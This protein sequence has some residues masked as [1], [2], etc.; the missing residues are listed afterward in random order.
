[1]KCRIE[2]DSL[3]NCEGGWESHRWEVGNQDRKVGEIILF[4]NQC[5]CEI[6]TFVDVEGYLWEVGEVNEDENT[7]YLYDREN[8]ECDLTLQVV[9]STA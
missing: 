5:G 8:L 3:T 2:V 6:I 7:V 1:M 4:C 9:S